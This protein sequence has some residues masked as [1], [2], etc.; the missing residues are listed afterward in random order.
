[1]IVTS[2]S[3]QHEYTI[4]NLSIIGEVD[5]LENVAYCW[6]EIEGF[7]KFGS[8]V[9]NG[10]ADGPFVYCGFK[11]A[12][13][14]VRRTNDTGDWIIFDSSRSPVNGSNLFLYPNLTNTDAPTNIGFDFLSNGFKLRGAISNRNASGGTYIF[15][16][17]AESPFTTANAK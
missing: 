3:V 2:N 9:G 10:N 17:F 14:L 13:L 12:W 5:G 1:M 11:P 8:Y 4:P 15:A 16:A 7:S 6:A